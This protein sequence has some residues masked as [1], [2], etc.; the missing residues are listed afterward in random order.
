MYAQVD[1]EGNQFLLLDVIIDH[2]CDNGISRRDIEPTEG[3]MS[4]IKRK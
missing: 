1:S 3:D 2:K 4:K